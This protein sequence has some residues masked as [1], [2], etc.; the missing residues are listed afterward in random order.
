MLSGSFTQSTNFRNSFVALSISRKIF[1]SLATR[2]QS[3][4]E[5]KKKT[6]SDGKNKNLVRQLSLELP[7]ASYLGNSK[8]V[9][10]SDR[11]EDI[12]KAYVGTAMEK[13]RT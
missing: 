2:V 6:V 12:D 9:S 13:G 3:Y 11:C 4:F 5:K 7:R 8:L 10:F 1:P